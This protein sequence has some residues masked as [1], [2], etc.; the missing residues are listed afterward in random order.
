M[1]PPDWWKRRVP[2]RRLG[3]REVDKDLEV[4]EAPPLLLLHTVL[5]YHSALTAAGWSPKVLI[6]RLSRLS[7]MD[8]RGARTIK[9]LA[10]LCRAGRTRLILSDVQSNARRGL[11]EEGVL[12]EVGPLNVFAQ[13]D[14]ALMRARQLLGAEPK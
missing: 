9:I 14:Q 13:W 8:R 4:F 11:G 12:D 1:S 5:S 2:A 10:G 7:S 6:V 3:H